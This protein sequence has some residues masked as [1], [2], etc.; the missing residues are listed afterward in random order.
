MRARGT[1]DAVITDSGG[2]A[3]A[4]MLAGSLMRA[5][6]AKGMATTKSRMPAAIQAMR[7]PRCFAVR[8]GVK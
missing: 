2:I 8:V 7:R 6:K 4:T 5:I 3:R 1:K